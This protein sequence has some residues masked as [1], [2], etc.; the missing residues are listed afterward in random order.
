MK[1]MSSLLA[2][3]LVLTM[4]MGMAIT[5]SAGEKA[6]KV[7]G[8]VFQEDQFMKLVQLG[9]QKCAEDY[10]VEYNLANTNGDTTKE[11]ELVNTYIAQDFDGIAICPINETTSVEV[12]RKANEEGVLVAASNLELKNAPFIVGG[13]TSNQYDLCVP[14]GLVAKKF[15]EEHF[16]DKAV[17]KVAML[18][19][20]SVLPEVTHDRW[21][22]FLDQ[23]KDIPGKEIQVVATQDGWL[24]DKAFAAVDGILAANPD[25]DI[26]Y[27]FNDGSTIGGTMAIKNAGLAGKCFVFGIDA[28][29]QVVEM[30]KSED[31]ILQCV[32][33]QDPYTMGYLT[34]ELL[35]KAMKGEDYSATKG[36]V[37]YT[38]YI[39]LERGNN[40][41]LDA[42]VA[43][44]EVKMG[45]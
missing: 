9:Y 30:L 31:N 34:M 28:S 10:G 5:A 42:F 36:K 23:I 38:D 35:I 29:V 24:Q 15:I 17:I 12:L 6:L 8:V 39:L 11:L 40:E 33:G 3:L 25:L 18:G 44:L 37:F 20:E 7:A 2:A 14:S 19:A 41:K 1:R 27:G 32:T 4:L 13:Y 26:F 43:D 21:N 45:K 16:A 22:G